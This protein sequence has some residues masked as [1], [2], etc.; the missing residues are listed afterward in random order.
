MIDMARIDLDHLA[1]SLGVHGNGRGYRLFC[2]ACQP[3]GGRTP[4][5][6]L[7]DNGDKGRWRCFKCH[8]HGDAA[9]LVELAL[10][11][12]PGDGLRW[13]RE[14][15][16]GD[17]GQRTADRPRT[18]PRPDMTGKTS[19]AASA[20]LADYLKHLLGPRSK[21]VADYWRARGVG[22]EIL[23]AVGVRYLGPNEHWRIHDAMAKVHGMDALIAAGLAKRPKSE[24]KKHY[25]PTAIY[26]GVGVPCC[27][28]PHI[29]DGH[30]IAVKIRP[31]VNKA[32]AE[33]LQCPRFLAIGSP[34]LYNAD[35]LRSADGR[36][37][38]IAE[39]ESDTLRLLAAGAIAVGVAGT[40]GW[41]SAWAP[42]FANAA[43]VTVYAD[44]DS[45]GRKSA[46]RIGRDLLRIMPDRVQIIQL[47]EGMDVSDYLNGAP[48]P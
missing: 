30:V 36:Q 25:P 38:H 11:L 37:V 20:I 19:A 24:G 33:R 6:S 32:E 16:H 2:P 21:P 27:A 1:A 15:G 22:P 8:R 17:A 39:G 41:D 40:S 18:K 46:H 7:N 26:Q 13:L 3:S 44:G 12:Q 28:L 35:A 43:R 45:A 48:M 10:G 23:H 31:L 29:L 5:L 42:R 34:V 47:P 9:D 14:H 4:D